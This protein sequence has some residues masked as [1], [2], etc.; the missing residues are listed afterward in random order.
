VFVSAFGE[1]GVSHHW[2]CTIP[3]DKPG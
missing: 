1:H 3:M 2:N